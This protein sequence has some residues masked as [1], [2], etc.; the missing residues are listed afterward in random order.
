MIWLIIIPVLI[1]I[2]GFISAYMV[3]KDGVDE[4]IYIGSETLKHINM[5]KKFNGIAGIL[6]ILANLIGSFGSVFCFILADYT[7]TSVLWYV[8]GAVLGL[9]FL[10][11]WGSKF[12]GGGKSK[13]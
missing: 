6:F 13:R 3:E 1:V 8:I 10:G 9:G 11:F 12:L 2:P 4:K 5:E 7:N